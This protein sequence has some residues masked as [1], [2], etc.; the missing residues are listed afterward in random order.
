VDAGD[1]PTEAVHRLPR[2]SI[3]AGFYR[4]AVIDDR[5]EHSPVRDARF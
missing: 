1:P 5:L 3:V 4:A 2:M